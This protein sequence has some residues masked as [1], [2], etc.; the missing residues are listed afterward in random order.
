[1]TR[2]LGPRLNRT[3]P[4]FV[5]PN[6]AQHPHQL[7]DLMGEKGLILGFMG[8]VWM[9]SNVRRLIWLQ[10]HA[11]TFISMGVNVALVATDQPHM[12]YGFFMSSPT[13]PSFPLLAD[14]DGVVHR[15]FE[16]T[17][18]SGMILLDRNRVMRHKWLVPHERVWPSL[19]DML[20]I[21]E[22]V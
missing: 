9:P 20:E 19:Q 15:L 3:A 17:A 12:L 21:V 4:D 13:P 7:D 22:S 1:M 14:T 16:M 5:V 6:H 2:E 8:D 11:Y 10:H 18:Y